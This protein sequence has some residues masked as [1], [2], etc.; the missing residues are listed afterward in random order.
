MGLEGFA[1]KVNVTGEVELADPDKGETVSHGLL[2]SRA[3]VNPTAAPVLVSVICWLAGAC[4]ANGAVKLSELLLALS[5]GLSL[6]TRVTKT[7]WTGV[8]EAGVAPTLTF[9]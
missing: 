2:E 5:R 8:P 4:P 7:G 9:V 1:V 6:T 3:T